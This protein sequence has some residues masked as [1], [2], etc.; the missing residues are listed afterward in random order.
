MGVMPRVYKSI[1]PF[2]R[3]MSRVE[4]KGHGGCWVYTGNATKNG[5]SLVTEGHSG[6]HYGHRLVYQRLVGLIP[7]GYRL[8]HE[9]ENPL[10]VNP[11]HLTPESARTHAN[12]HGLGIGSCPACGADDWYVRKDNGSRQCRECRRLRRAKMVQPCPQCG[13]QFSGEAATCSPRCGTLYANSKKPPKVPP[14]HGDYLRYKTHKCRCDG[15]R[16]A[17]RQYENERRQKS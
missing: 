8:H 7:G 10:C 17:N 9:C 3:L 16:A 6:W 5:Y 11:D 2:D 12:R 14:P 4:K 13:E 1:D 15:C